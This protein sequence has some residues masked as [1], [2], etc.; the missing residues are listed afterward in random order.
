MKYTYLKLSDA[1][2]ETIYKALCKSYQGWEDFS[3][4]ENDWKEF[5]KD[6]HEFPDTIGSSGFATFLGETIVGFISWDPRQFPSYVIIGHN[7]VLPKYRNQGIGKQQIT[8]ALNS[9]QQHGF[10]IARVS[11]KRDSFFKYSRRMYESCGF[12]ECSPYRNDGEN[13]IYYSMELKNH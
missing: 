13:M 8:K 12:I 9:F 3:K 5:D 2:S 1:E 10:E 6:I 11:T 4:W 7:C